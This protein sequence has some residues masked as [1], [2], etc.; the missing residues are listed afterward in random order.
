MYIKRDDVRIE[1]YRASGPGGQRRNKKETAVRI[2]HLPTRIMAV[3]AD[4]RS[5]VRNKAIALKRLEK[6]LGILFRKKKKR[7][8]TKRPVRVK[9]MILQEKRI[10]GEIKRLRALVKSRGY[11]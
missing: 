6:K 2:T 10:K 7:L 8:R 1:F 5:Q 11:E 4:E 9:E 3:S